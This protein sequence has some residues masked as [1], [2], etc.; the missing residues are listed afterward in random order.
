MIRKINQ[1]DKS[2]YL[3]MANDFYHSEAVLHVVDSFNFEKTFEE[4]ISSDV[5]ADCY[6]HE[7]E[8]RADAYLL[9]AK[10]FSQEAGGVCVWIEEIYVLPQA[11]GRGIGTALINKVFDTYG[12]AARFR[13]EVEKDN[14]SAV[15][16]YRRLGFKNLDYLQMIKDA[17]I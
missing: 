11:R 13:L 5:Y 17:H 4:L 14:K 12:N 8:G 2:I 1:S 15:D 16:L 9:T 7:S 3:Q 10:T 6:I